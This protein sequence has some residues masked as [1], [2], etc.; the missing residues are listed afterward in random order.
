MKTLFADGTG[1]NSIIQL[2]INSYSYGFT[3]VDFAWA[4]M[5]NPKDN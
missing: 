3:V 5:P 1:M 4:G 2:L